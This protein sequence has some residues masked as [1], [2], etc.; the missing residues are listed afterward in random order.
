MTRLGGSRRRALLLCGAPAPRGASGRCEVSA[1][2]DAE[3]ARAADLLEAG[4]RG[5]AEAILDE[6]RREG[7]PAGLGRARGSPARRPTTRGAQDC[8]GGGRAARGVRRPDRPRGLPAACARAEALELAGRPDEALEAARRAFEAEGPLRVPGARGDRSWRAC[9][10]SAGRPREAVRRP[11]ARGRRGRDRPET[12]AEVAIGRIR[13]GLAVGRPGGGAR[14][15]ARACS[16][17]RRRYD[18]ARGHAGLRAAGGARGR[19]RPDARRAG[20]A[21]PRAG[22]RRRCAAW[23]A[24]CSRRTGPRRGPRASA[25]RICSRSRA[26]SSPSRSDRDAE[27]T[28]ARVPDDGTLAAYEARL[29]RCDLVLARL[30]GKAPAE[31]DARDDPRLEPVVAR[32]RGADAPRRCPSPVRRGA[33]ERLLRFAADAEDFDDGARAGARARRRTTPDG[34][35]GF[36]PLWRLSWKRYRAGDFAGARARASR[37]SRRSTATSRRRAALCVLA[38]AVP[39]GRGRG[40]R[41][42]GALRGA[43]RR[44]RRPTS[45]PASRAR[46]RRRA[47]ARSSAPLSRSV[48]GD[49]GLRARRRAAAPAD[50]RGGLGRGADAPALARARP[51]PGRRRT[52]RSAASSTA[53]VAI[54]RALPEIGTAEEGR[55][56]D[57]WRRLY[58]PIEEGGFLPRAREGVRP[59]RRRCCAASCGRRASSTPARSRGPARWA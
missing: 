37:R 27:A 16:W 53:A 35:E 24:L 9:S 39:R 4:Q 48:D 50:V 20:A 7:R 52:S 5:E 23:R 30:R 10:R 51:A 55:V 47:R 54:K 19:A 33:R 28:A 43:R 36:E 1:D 12:S 15:G 59:R 58:Y 42:A 22:R 56:P 45:T 40:R 18:A 25:A 31:A 57:G 21:R 17:R 13:L 6:I 34:L 29:F 41:S 3:F 11:G 2:F 38:G 14:G 44:R 8:G 26:A 49:R 32:A 46:A